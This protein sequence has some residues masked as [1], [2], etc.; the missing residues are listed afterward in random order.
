MAKFVVVGLINNLTGYGIFVLLSLLGS[1]AIPAM[2]VSYGIGMVISFVGNRSWT[3]S[4]RASFVPAVFRFLTANAVGYG[5]NLAILWIFVTQLGLAQ[6]PVQLFATAC[7]AVCTF[8]AMR[9]WVFRTG[10]G[11]AGE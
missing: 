8:L 10:R 2:T 1:A 11:D 9:L 4:H 3:F 5:V 6:I 7:V